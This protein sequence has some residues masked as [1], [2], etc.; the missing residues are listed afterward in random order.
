LEIP[1]VLGQVEAEDGCGEAGDE[2]GGGSKARL[3][4]FF[5]TDVEV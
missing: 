2:G 5:E 3:V 4:S 1:F